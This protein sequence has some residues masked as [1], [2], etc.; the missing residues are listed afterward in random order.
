M[1]AVAIGWW[2]LCS[3]S[4]RVRIQTPS[5]DDVHHASS[6][7]D[8]LAVPSFGLSAMYPTDSG[9]DS[10]EAGFD[11]SA[12]ESIGGAV[13]VSR[14]KEKRRQ[15][16]KTSRDKEFAVDQRKARR[17]DDWHRKKKDRTNVVAAMEE[18]VDNMKREND[19]MAMQINELKQQKAQLQAMLDGGG[20]KSG[21]AFGA[22]SSPVGSPAS[23]IVPM[24]SDY[25][26]SAPDS[27][28]SNAYSPLMEMLPDINE[29]DGLVPSYTEQLPDISAFDLDGPGMMI[30][31]V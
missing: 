27:P 30:S 12:N 20:L 31:T 11:H 10:Q 4:H 8:V 14:G 25:A 18:D 19:S 23:L 1:L 13:D 22:F 6:P 24:T 5:Q 17:R 21:A 29:M 28:M 3:D 9:L 7:A 2:C 16:R 26:S 15:K